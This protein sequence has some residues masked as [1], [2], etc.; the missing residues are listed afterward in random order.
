MEKKIEGVVMKTLKRVPDK[1]GA[2]K[3]LYL[4]KKKT[5]TYA[6][7][8]KI[9]KLALYDGRE[10][11]CLIKRPP[12]IWNGS[13]S[14]GNK[15]AIVANFAKLPHNSNEIDRTNPFTDKI[16]YGWTLRNGQLS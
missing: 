5:S 10:N 6:I 3:G 14:I 7:I 13:R 11:Y 16:I 1:R 4:Q 2:F 8:Q 9:V 15:L 12:K